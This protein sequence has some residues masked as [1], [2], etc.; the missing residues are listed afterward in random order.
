[1]TVLV[2][3]D[4]MRAAEA[5]TIAAGVPAHELM[6][7]AGVAIAD[8]VECIVAVP[9]DGTRRALGLAGPG[10]NGGDT[11]VALATLHQ[12]GWVCAA[13]LVDRPAFGELPASGSNLG[14]IAIVE[15]AEAGAFR[16]DV[17]L[18]GVYGIGGRATLG[19]S[20]AAAVSLARRE[21]A[22]RRVPL[23]AIDVPSGT[24]GETGAA[25]ERA[26][27]ADVTLCLGL[28]KIG[29]TREPA[30]TCVG[31]LIVVDIGIAPP[32]RGTR[33]EMIGADQVRT[34]LPHRRASAHKSDGGAVLIIGGSDNYYGAPRLAG[35]AALRVG[36]GLVT[37]A[38]PERLVTPLAGQVPELTFLSL[39]G[40]GT[41]QADT[42]LAFLES[43]AG[44]Y[45]AI[46]VGPG[47]G[48]DD[49]ASGLLDGILGSKNRHIQRASLVLD[50]DALFWLSRQAD[51]RRTLSGYACVLTPHPGELA[52]LNNV[53]V[54]HVL[55]DT[56][57]A[58]REAAQRLGQVVV[59][60]S[61]YSTV[62]H[63][64]GAVWLAP[65]SM[66][67]LATPGTG[68]VF[69]GLVGGL[70][71]Q[72]LRPHDGARVAMYVGAMAGRSARGIFG[73]VGAVA[74]DIIA[75]VPESLKQICEPVWDTQWLAGT[76]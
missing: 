18:D 5:A 9:P 29:L 65:R 51:Q 14:A 64:D 36:A 34:L 50:A 37:L 26:F 38:V 66:P 49:R 1:M 4:E 72:G 44:R 22:T 31:E 7:R 13:L 40:S 41:Q 45:S 52:R 76:R 20:A 55:D 69:S 47:L 75:L 17:I 71:A 61:G 30:A 70:L 43:S 23:I 32:D 28:P 54:S 57:A 63:T 8:W 67:E 48:R 2:T 19:D 10:N 25:D 73:T 58:G 21:R 3:P 46:V 60:K 42:I 39:A 62:V 53:A 12:R 35:E 24:D 15:A 11:L 16:A 33:P 68:D 74:S 59:V 27:P 56:I 6:R